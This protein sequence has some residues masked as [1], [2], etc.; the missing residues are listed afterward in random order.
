MFMQRIVLIPEVAAFICVMSGLDVTALTG[1]LLSRV[2]AVTLRTA[3]PLFMCDQWPDVVHRPGVVTGTALTIM[4]GAFLA[5]LVG[6][7]EVH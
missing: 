7:N 3:A 5:K 4:G 2:A 1:A 6:Q